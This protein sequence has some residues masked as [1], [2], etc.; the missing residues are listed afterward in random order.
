MSTSPERVAEAL[1]T[2]LK[3]TERLRSQNRRLVE[4][5]SEPIAIVGIGC[6]YP[7]GAD[8]PAALWQLLA[9]GGDAISAF[10]TDRGWDLEGIAAAEFDS[11]RASEGGFLDDAADFDSDFFGISPREALG[12]DPQQRLL[13]E[14][15]WEALEDAGIDPRALRGSRSGIFAGAMYHDYGWGLSPL[16]D[17]AAYLSTGG[18]SSLISGRVAYTLGLEGPTLSVDTA[19]SS[20]LVA[21]HLAA[22]A[23]RGGECSLALAGGVTVYSTPGVFIQFGRQR[24]L[25]PHG[26]SRSF[27]EGADGAGFSEGVGMLVLERLGDAQR[28]GHTVLATIRGSAVNQDGA[29]NGIAA[30]NGPSQEKVIRQAL[31]SAR[32]SPGEID[33][34]EGHGTGTALG[35]PI[36]AGALL[37]TY[38]LERPEGRP[39]RL[40]SI[41]SNIG[42][43][44][45][46]AG[47]AGVIKMVLALREGVLP[48]TLHVDRP[49]S[50]VDWSSG[51]IELLTEPMPWQPG[52]RPRRAAVSSFGATGTNAHLI[53]EEAPPDS[54]SEAAAGVDPDPA[55]SPLPGVLLLPLSAKAEPALRDA[56]RR[57]GSRLEAEPE[58]DPLDAGYSLATGRA[59]FEHRAVASGRDREQLLAGLAAI[60][61]G[62]SAGGVARGVSGPDRGAVFLFGGQGS[63]H[64]RMAAEL[65]ESSAAFA[66]RVDECERALS[67]HVEWSLG[68]VLRDREGSWLDR[69][70]V[71]Q[72][73]L[74]A[75]MVSLA[76][77]WRQLGVEPVGV[78]GHSQ[79]EIAAAHIAGG[80][81]LDDAARVVALRARAMTKIA[82]Q[83]GM[84]SVSLSAEQLAPRLEPFRERLA[85]AAINGP[86]SLVVSGDTD[87]I[88][89]LRASCESEGV[90]AQPIAVDYAAHSAQIEALREEL[91]DA[92]APISPRQ[93][94]IPFHST[95]TGGLL[96]TSRLDAEYWYRN[97]RQTVLLQ[98]VLGSLLEAGRRAFVE[99]SPHPVLGFGFEE[100][101]AASAEVEGATVLGTLRRDDGGPDRFALS[102]AEAHAAGI[103]LDWEAVFAGS[104]T[105]RVSVPTYPF[106]RKRYWLSPGAGSGDVADAG[107]SDAGHPLLSAVVEDPTGDGIVLTGRLSLSAQ[108]WLG[109]HA[110]AGT[111]LLPGTAFLEMALRAAEEIGAGAVEDLTL[112]APLILPEQG[113]VRVQVVTGALGGEGRSEVSIHS[114]PAGEGEDAVEWT[115]HALGVLAAEA[116]PPPRS[117]GEW[118][119]AAAEPLDLELL[120]DRLAEAGFEYGPA[121]QGVGAAWLAG[122]EIHVEVSLPEEQARRAED[123]A[124]HPALL[125]AAGHS[126]LDLALGAGSDE[127]SGMALPFAWRGVSL[128]AKGASALRLRIGLGEDGGGLAAFD[129][130]GAPVASV[131]SVVMRPVDPAVLRALN[132]RRLPLH[133]LGWV[134]LEPSE[135]IEAGGLRLAVLGERGTEGPGGERYPDLGAL[136]EAVADGAAVP[137]VLLVDERAG[138]GPEALP[139]AAHTRA[140]RTLELVQSFLAAESLEDCR[141]CLLT[142]GAVPVADG[143]APDLATAPLW[144]LMRSASSEH[145][146]RFAVIDSDDSEASAEAL[147]GA[148]AA[149]AE[150]PQ[151]ALRAGETLV[152][153][154]TRAELPE[155]ID[156]EPIDPERTV[157]ISG[158]TSGIGALLARHL[159]VEHGARQLLLVSRRGRE[160]AGVGQLEAELTELGATV[161][162]AACDVADRAQLEA[163]LGSTPAEHPLGA[164]FHSAGVLDDG[165]LEALDAERLE[166][167][168]RPKVDAA[169]HLHEL[170][171][172]AG[173]SAFVLFSSVMGVLG[174]AAQA[175]YAAANAFLDALAAYRQAAG[176]PAKSL[177]WGGWAQESSMI[178]SAPD[179]AALTR[180]V[181][182][183]RKRLGVVPMAPEQGLALL[184]A[185]LALPDRQLVPVAFDGAVLRSQASTGTLPVV[186]RGLVRVPVK[187]DRDGNSL[188]ERLAAVPEAKREAVV[189]D[190]VRGNVADVLG[191]PSATEVEP[192]RAFRDLGFDS[193]AAVELRNRLAAATGLRLAPTIVFDH[194]AP[195]SLARYMLSEAMG[196]AVAAATPQA[197]AATA[198][199]IAIVGMAC[200][201]PGGA[202]SPTALW[203]LLLAGTDAISGF[204]EDRGWDLERLYSPDPDEPGTCYA[205]EGGFLADAGEFDPGFFGISPRE[206]LAMDPQ[207]RVLLESCWEAFEDG[208]I[209]PRQLRGTETGVFAG[210]MY[211]DY[212]VADQGMGM[213][214]AGVSG[215]I[216]Y[217]FGLEGPTMTID[218]ACSSSL[219]AM[220]LAGQALRGGECSLA[221]AGG[222]TVLATPGV[223]NFFSRQ[224]GLAADGR[225]K[226]FSESADG[227]GIAEGSGVLVLERLSDAERNGHPILATI[228]GS[229]VNQDGASNGF[230]APNGPSQERV[231]RQALA[232]AGLAPQDVDAVEGHGTGTALGDPIEAGALLATYGQDRER[233]LKLGSIKSNLGHPQAAAGVAGAIKMVM[234][235]REGVL[236]KTLHVDEPS[237][238]VDWEAGEIELLTETQPWQR[239]GAPRR[240]GVSSFG[241]S[242]TN[243]HLILEEAVD[244]GPGEGE[245]ESAAPAE[246]ADTRPGPILLPLSAKTE[247]ALAAAAGRLAAHLQEN[248]EVDVL[249][250]AYSLATTR[251]QLEQRAVVVGDDRDQL[252][253]GLAAVR[254]GEAGAG[255]ALGRARTGAKLAYLFSGQGSQRP[256]M[257]SELYAAHPAFAEAFDR[258]CE[259]LDAELGLSLREIVFDSGEGAAERLADTAFA[260]PALFAIEVA[261]FRLLESFGLAPDLLAGHSIG[262]LSAAH[263]AG[264]FSLADAARLVA[265]RGRLMGE[266]PGGGSML[267]LQATEA[268]AVEAIRGSEAELSLAAI[269]GPRSVVLSGAE[270]AI[271][272]AEEHWR[273]AGRKTKRLEV[274]HAFHSPLI[275]PML[276]QFEVIARELDYAEP[277]IP[278]V[279]NLSG[280]LLSAEQATDPAYWVSHA[281]QPVRFADA[282]RALRGQGATAF[283]ELGPEAVLSAMAQECVEGEDAAGPAGSFAPSL[284]AKQAEP[285]TLALAAATAQAGGIALDWE[286]LFRPAAPRRVKLPTYPFQRKRYWLDSTTQGG[287]A[288]LSAAGQAPAD[289]PLLG[290]SIAVAGGDAVLLTGRISR[291]T[292]PWLGDHAL[293]G[294][295]PLPGTALVEMALRA[296]AEHGAAT[297][298]ELVLQAPLVLPERGGVQLQASVAAADEEGRREVTIHSRPDGGEDGGL[299][300]APDWTCNAQGVLAPAAAPRAEPLASWPPQ[301]AEPLEVLDLYQ[302]LAEHGIDYGPA[303]QAVRA[304]WRLG[305][306]LLVE[307]SLPEEQVQEAGRYG[308]HPALFDAIGHVG[309]DLAL[310]ADSEDGEPVELALPFA[311]RGVRIASPGASSLRVRIS[312]AG[313]GHGLV[314]YDQSGEPVVSVDS[315]VVRPLERGQLSPPRRRLPLHRLEWVEADASPS[316][317]STP[318]RVVEIAGDEAGKGALAERAHA[319]LRE[320]LELLQGWLADERSG[321]DRLCIQSRG[322]VAVGPGESPD[323]TVAAIWGLLRSAQSEH[324]DRFALIDSDGT[325]A[326]LEALPAALA[327]SGGQAQIALREGRAL[328]PRLARVDTNAEEDE[329]APIDPASTVLITGG[330]SGLGALLARHLAEEHGARH[331][332]LVSRRGAGAEGASE[333][334]EDLRALGAEP[335]IAACDAS[336]RAQLGALLDSIPAERPLGAVIHSAGLVEDGLLESLDPASL[337][338]VLAAKLDAAWNLHELTA[339]APLSRFVMFSSVAGILGSPGQSNYAAANT[340]LDALAAHRAAAG[341]PAVSL[342]WGA[343]AQATGMTGHLGEADVSR[344]RRSGLAA[345][346]PRLG[347]E[348]FDAACSRPEPL[349]APVAFDAAGL[350]A[351]ATAG[352]LPAILSGLAGPLAP[353]D[354]ERRSLAARLAGVPPLERQRIAL[355]LVRGHVAAVLGHASAAEIDP[356]AAFMDLGFDSLAAVELR[357][358]LS[359]AT[360]LRLQQTVVF[361]YPSCAAL[362]RH[363]LDRVAPEPDSDGQAGPEDDGAEDAHAELASMSHEEMFELIDEEFGAR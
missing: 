94:E 345:I 132:S 165:M 213:T 9:T 355:E 191:Y 179:S 28:Q 184:D 339:E 220:H 219:V 156:A 241:A 32:L 186:L 275:E 199:P 95:V 71:V 269:N 334:L 204:P 79:G 278:I 13:L 77:L 308:M 228:R 7:G 89:E 116:A 41:K 75:V 145:P 260:Q 34:V 183:V 33:A 14:A 319:R 11:S 293:G 154:L 251:T 346:S 121:F 117:L 312:P 149:G 329:A 39:L 133:R 274:S 22:Q 61:A 348:L 105:K 24:V 57:L 311:W 63:Q 325:D 264:V 48:Q 352:T 146:G 281:R 87:A 239:N 252:L 361:D 96:E 222:V 185:S 299:D 178:G 235:M 272:A 350:R 115:C 141:L 1:R 282:V 148:L 349:L 12:M 101:I 17:A 237:T 188:A 338:R 123:F 136:L 268:E 286:T 2:S 171:A 62:G 217:T 214:S 192:E 19:C 360:G 236:P 147:A 261:L 42:H 18:S 254:E 218:T 283:L 238:K 151:I 256:G 255:V 64:V 88:G 317:G 166:R 74:F 59:A 83:G 125:D 303:F 31:E 25:S 162:I 107:L 247:V 195:A 111:T 98:P 164:V 44:Q 305:D 276:A 301:G 50:M 128:H 10:P 8:S 46:A 357:N 250:A 182:Q 5:A 267:A 93:G 143:E 362:T 226:A 81:S 23:L 161:T 310:S 103:E 320:V 65:L 302:R 330:T 284:R 180:L 215:R 35:D 234:A 137:G 231:I 233:P 249:D 257:G 354:G 358:R 316:N 270:A 243:A 341:L 139:T 169:W 80:L 176:L 359:A 277:R 205:R 20:S 321:E 56:A 244:A 202:S 189:V 155:Q 130:N 340:F 194:P 271:A 129:R 118:P 3:E 292:H 198:E 333:L 174:G 265:A 313:E 351:A 356:G 51:A 187:R 140:Q 112:Q 142:A 15:S 296:G 197:A 294:A 26:R 122:E 76:Q 43:P 66:D 295:V 108:P 27:A 232:N 86:A 336:D 322:A 304:A 126:G 6:R 170:T 124:L 21:L 221:L 298:E 280:A 173:L 78:V 114:R 52:E 224:R 211:Q 134:G 245:G 209:D 92:F 68:E 206:A 318:T 113:A 109:D 53:L 328:V 91:L 331:L 55:E 353:D 60:A 246:R 242:G 72:P 335:E 73:A 163:L 285:T 135:K 287:P 288:A 177:A 138:A 153:R 208:G 47:V 300:D 323:L 363:L 307:A 343:W 229:A 290:A 342:A 190:L 131:D 36:E 175:N 67:P 266:L 85:L 227:T 193:L 248:P 314:G 332:L 347:L 289:H 58:L 167:V 82:G 49:S 324:P 259:P 258:V 327:A 168:M 240:A 90:R 337:D 106:Q 297:L 273:A 160:A 196:K 110:V 54:S 181:N 150:E 152:P 144:G 326:S 203:E 225:S 207:E 69:L 159:V 200:R 29:S 172:D 16:Q 309:V 210:V 216:A 70:D 38:G 223:L 84:L 37:T 253:R 120:Y 127:G 263:L 306:E 119:P 291:S 104:A 158:G 100:A 45:A 157:L 279:S 40:G 99:I 344:V 102:L 230:T 212:G 315:L 30:P 262:E 4:A 97:L 201:Y